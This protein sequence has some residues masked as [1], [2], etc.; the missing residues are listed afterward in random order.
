MAFR[1]MPRRLETE[2]D[3]TLFSS[4]LLITTSLVKLL[5]GNDPLRH[6]R[7]NKQGVEA[8][9]EHLGFAD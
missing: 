2:D 4:H 5:Q 3:R 7:V 9:G 1:S 8:P 6:A